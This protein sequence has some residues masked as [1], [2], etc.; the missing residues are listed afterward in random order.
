M[1]NGDRRG[2]AGT[3]PRT[4]RGMGYC[5]GYDSPGYTNGRGLGRG[6]GFNVGFGPG[7][8]TGRGFGRRTFFSYADTGTR[9]EDEA[10]LLKEEENYLQESLD[11]VRRR[12]GE[13][14]KEKEKEK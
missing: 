3:G 12:I 5:S 11:S 6:R 8:G 4:G 13:L 10:D 14:R 7:R 9:Y 1:P 2:P